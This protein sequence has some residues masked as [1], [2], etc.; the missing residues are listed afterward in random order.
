MCDWRYR[1]VCS[2]KR[3]RAINLGARVKNTLCTTSNQ[4]CTTC[5]DCREF[6]ICSV[7]VRLCV[8]HKCI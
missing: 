1:F 2:T 5:V 4:N 3:F 8:F 6:I 7:Y